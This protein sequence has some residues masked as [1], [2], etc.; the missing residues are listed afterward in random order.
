MLSEVFLNEIGDLSYI[1]S[2]TPGVWLDAQV[3]QLKQQKSGAGVFAGAA[4]AFGALDE[5]AIIEL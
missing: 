3:Y 5:N 2:Q 1:I 4:D